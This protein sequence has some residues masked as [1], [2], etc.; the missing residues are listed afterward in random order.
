MADPRPLGNRGLAVVAEFAVGSGGLLQDSARQAHL[1]EHLLAPANA[2]LAYSEHLHDQARRLGRGPA[3][4]ESHPRLRPP[5]H[6]PAGGRRHRAGPGPGHA[7]HIAPRPALAPR[8]HHRLRRAAGRGRGTGRTSGPGATDRA[9]ARV[10][11]PRRPADPGSR[12]ASGA[13]P[14]NWPRPCALPPADCTLWPPPV[15]ATSS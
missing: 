15:P 9:G 12:G 10:P 13:V 1:R 4:P 3:P 8:R 2:I 11:G 6:P 7:S 5:G 14:T